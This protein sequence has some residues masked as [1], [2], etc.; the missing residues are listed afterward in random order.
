M[1]TIIQGV[2]F[3]H[4][5]LKKGAQLG[6]RMENAFYQHSID[7]K[8][9]YRICCG[10]H[11][12][13]AKEINTLRITWPEKQ[14]KTN[15]L[16]G[17]KLYQI[18][19][20]VNDLYGVDQLGLSYGS[21]ELID[22]LEKHSFLDQNI[23]KCR[24]SLSKKPDKPPEKRR[25]FYSGEI[26][27]NVSVDND[28]ADKEPQSSISVDNLDETLIKEMRKKLLDYALQPKIDKGRNSTDLEVEHSLTHREIYDLIKLAQE[29]GY[30]LE[31]KAELSYV[32]K[33]V[34]ISEPNED[35]PT[36]DEMRLVTYPPET[37][38][39]VGFISEQK[40][41]IKARESRGLMG[42]SRRAILTKAKIVDLE[43]PKVKFSYSGP[44]SEYFS[45]QTPKHW[46]IELILNKPVEE[47]L[48]LAKQIFE[49]T[50]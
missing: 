11:T 12:W 44:V 6:F 39:S 8:S 7:P 50:V 47:D 24:I 20:A 27:F 30:Q 21:K 2:E 15:F 22:F 38:K 33:Y 14:H 25:V 32:G 41:K 34:G 9:G 35:N 26:S 5:T 31:D 13:E 18:A 3:I 48:E 23:S 29:H 1:E 40:T 28:K 37:I 16:S 19:E 10:I 43:E 49:V 45:S 36:L 4:D 17:E 42:R 46:E